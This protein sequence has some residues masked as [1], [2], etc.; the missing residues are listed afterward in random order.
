M[1]A[2]PSKLMVALR[3]LHRPPGNWTHGVTN[4]TAKHVFLSALVTR[5]LSNLIIFSTRLGYIQFVRPPETP[6]GNHHSP[7]VGLLQLLQD[8]F[9]FLFQAILHYEKSQKC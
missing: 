6:T 2:L 5:T 1:W 9:G 8:W 7:D 3:E 4:L